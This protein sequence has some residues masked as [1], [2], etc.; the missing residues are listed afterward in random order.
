M[1]SATMQPSPTESDA[2]LSSSSWDAEAETLIGEEVPPR[3]PSPSDPDAEGNYSDT[4]NVYVV[5]YNGADGVDC[6]VAIRKW[7]KHRDIDASGG[8][9][10]FGDLFRIEDHEGSL[11]IVRQ[12]DIAYE[13]L[14]GW[15]DSHVVAA[16]DALS[17]DKVENVISAVEVG[18]EEQGLTSDAWV[19]KAMETLDSE[20][21]L[22]EIDHD[23]EA[24]EHQ[25]NSTGL[26]P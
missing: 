9:L 10:S 22:F 6:A 24:A 25:R 13:S 11:C 7:R 8:L 21:Y 5:K 2:T 23:D 18:R 17:L 20:G 1:N 19:L 26:V 4:Y 3:S 15:C 12:E 14:Q 16:I